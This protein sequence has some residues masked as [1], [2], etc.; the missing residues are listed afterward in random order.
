MFYIQRGCERQPQH[1]AY[2]LINSH[3]PEN[4]WN[5]L[6]STSGLNKCPIEIIQRIKTKSMTSQGYIRDLTRGLMLAF[7]LL[8]PGS[9]FPLHLSRDI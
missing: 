5:D 9:A 4:D 6:D 8:Q 2:L 1:S 7:A 3:E